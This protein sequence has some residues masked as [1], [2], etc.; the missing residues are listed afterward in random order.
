[1]YGSVCLLF[2]IHCAHPKNNFFQFPLQLGAK[3]LVISQLTINILGVLRRHWVPSVTN[4]HTRTGVNISSCNNSKSSSS[5]SSKVD[6]PKLRQPNTYLQLTQDRCMQRTM[7]N[8]TFVVRYV[9]CAIT[10][11]AC[12]SGVRKFGFGVLHVYSKGI[13]HVHGTHCG[14]FLRACLNAICRALL[15]DTIATTMGKRK[16]A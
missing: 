15:E 9:R 6:H 3:F 7:K 2:G 4:P 12:V 11:R 1:M 13:I 5:N 10:K 8:L 16:K 14:R